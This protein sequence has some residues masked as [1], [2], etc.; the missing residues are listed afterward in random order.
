MSENM[1]A[2]RI[3]E[4]LESLLVQVIEEARSKMEQGEIFPPFTATV[5][6]DKLFTETHEGDIDECFASAN[7]AVL[8]AAGARLYAF[9]YDGYIDTDEGDKDAI[10]AEGGLAGDPQAVAVGMMYTMDE[11]GA[12]T[13]FDDE[14]VYI[15]ETRNFLADAEPVSRDEEVAKE[16]K[17]TEE[18]DEAQEA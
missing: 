15:A 2:P 5:V 3:D 11:E 13:G 10:I 18:G 4:E 12:V 16:T 7:D 6:G 14:I 9:C 8:N 1:E 17:E